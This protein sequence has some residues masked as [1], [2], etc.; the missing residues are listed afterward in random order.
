MSHECIMV[1][2]RSQSLYIGWKRVRRLDGAI[3]ELVFVLRYHGSLHLPIPQVI[4]GTYELEGDHGSGWTFIRM[5]L[6]GFKVCL[7]YPVCKRCKLRRGRGRGGII[8]F[9]M[10]SC[11]RAQY[12]QIPSQNLEKLICAGE[13]TACSFYSLLCVHI[14]TIPRGL[15]LSCKRVIAEKIIMESVTKNCQKEN[16]L[17]L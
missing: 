1:L 7:N 13:M 2:Q 6:F 9:S 17:D 14:Y 5:K 3:R 16:I 4:I 10:V 12:L 8:V 15:P 11:S